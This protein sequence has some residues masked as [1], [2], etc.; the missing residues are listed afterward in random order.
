[1]GKQPG[2]CLFLVEEELRAAFMGGKLGLHARQ[3]RHN[4]ERETECAR[5]LPQQ[6]LAKGGESAQPLGRHSPDVDKCNVSVL[7]RG[8]GAEC[9]VALCNQAFNVFGREGAGKSEA[10]EMDIGFDVDREPAAR[11]ISHPLSSAF[12]GW[13]ITPRSNSRKNGSDVRLSTRQVVNMAHR[14]VLLGTN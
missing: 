8:Q 10:G 4:E 5:F 7:C 2:P 9:A 12:G 13:S 14:F 11:H 3:V 6:Q 1:M